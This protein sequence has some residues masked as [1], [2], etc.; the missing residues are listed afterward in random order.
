MR[1]VAQHG[2][3]GMMKGQVGMPTAIPTLMFHI[4]IVQ[5]QKIHN[6]QCSS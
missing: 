4:A 6:T 3:D 1:N 5:Y 2:T